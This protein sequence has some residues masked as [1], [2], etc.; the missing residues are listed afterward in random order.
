MTFPQTPQLWENDTTLVF[1]LLWWDIQ[2]A[3]RILF[4]FWCLWIK[5]VEREVCASSSRWPLFSWP[6]CG[7]DIWSERNKGLNRCVVYFLV[8]LAVTVVLLT[9][10][11]KQSTTFRTS[12]VY[13]HVSS[14]KKRRGCCLWCLRRSHRSRN[15]RSFWIAQ[16]VLFLSLL[17]W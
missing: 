15:G 9:W 1:Y 14:P 16:C 7:G 2:N 5:L 12:C 11:V 3:M 4:L 13:R 6:Y 17:T 8:M 10:F